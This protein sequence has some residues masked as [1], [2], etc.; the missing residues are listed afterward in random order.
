MKKELYRTLNKEK[1]DNIR[2]K[3]ELLN[4]KYKLKVNLQRS[5]TLMNAKDPYGVRNNNNTTEYIILVDKKDYEKSK[6]AL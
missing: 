2:G 1:I 3:L 4:I 5:L 6:S